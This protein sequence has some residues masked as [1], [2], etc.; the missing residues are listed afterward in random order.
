[1]KRPFTITTAMLNCTLVAVLVV[2]AVA[3]N[4]VGSLPTSS[5]TNDVFYHVSVTFY[6]TAA[7]DNETATMLTYEVDEIPIA[8]EE[9]GTVQLH[10]LH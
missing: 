8:Y 5:G 2:L 10:T 3:F 7:C 1:M 9:Q 6:G 4:T